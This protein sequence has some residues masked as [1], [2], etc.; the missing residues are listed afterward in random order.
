MKAIKQSYTRFLLPENMTKKL[1]LDTFK[2]FFV[3]NE[4]IN[5]TEDFSI[6]DSFSWQLHNHRLLAIRHQNSHISLWNEKDL[7]DPGLSMNIENI[8]TKAKFW[9]DFPESPAKDILQDIL[10]LRALDPVYQ[11]TLKVEQFNFQNDE[12]KILVYCQLISIS[13]PNKPRIFLMRQAKIIPVTG[14]KSEN[15]QAIELLKEL[16]GF[17]PRLPPL[18]SLL[19]ALGIT[20]QPFNIKPEL[21]LS[22]AM[23]ARAAASSIIAIMIAKQR[24]TEPG[25]IKDIDSEYLHHFRVALR[26]IRAAIAQ[27]K[28]VF[29]ENDVLM[30][31]ERFGSLAR[32]T[33]SLRD[34][35]VFIIDK[36]RYMSFLPESLRD[37]L[38]PMFSDF[39]KSRVSEVK[40]ISKWLSSNVYQQEIVELQAL[41]E[42][43]YSTIET[44]WSEKPS[45]E[46]AVKKIH[47]RYKKIQYAAA[48]I[49]HSTPDENIHSIRIECKKLR[50]LLHFFG[51]LFDK[52]QVKV[53]GNHLK[54]LQN[55][56][57]IFNDL[58]VQGKFLENYLNEI[59][60]KPKKD[61][62]LIA[63]L[64]GLIS[65]LHTMQMQEREKCISELDIF[66]NAEN[67]QLFNKTF[68]HEQNKMKIE[69]KL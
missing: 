48:N 39:E 59:E 42:N 12:G 14:Y 33:N 23:S 20:P 58:T 8:N 29:P 6:L 11:G 21:S 27:L 36:A 60:H 7:L 51:N 68:S 44:K 32:E 35:D 57:G 31:K 1:F 50:Y 69:S 17:E 45:I 28:E 15:K 53:A 3:V 41:F 67:R 47:K 9:W 65:T 55:T 64:G 16:G 4:V 19:S 66:S 62:M 63:A 38:L 46:L 40:R 13:D 34:L 18:D 54:S 56:L 30:L 24:L 49:T 5:K 2:K 10:K 25:I 52:K 61:I 43:G 37:G 22:P 26:M